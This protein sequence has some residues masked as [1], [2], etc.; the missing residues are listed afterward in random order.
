MKRKC[1][2]LGSS[3]VSILLISTL[4]GCT[5]PGSNPVSSAST[6]S[7]ESTENST[8]PLTMLPPETDGEAI[9]G[10]TGDNLDS[11]VRPGGGSGSFKQEM[12]IN[13]SGLDW[14]KSSYSK[15]NGWITR[16]FTFTNDNEGKCIMQADVTTKA[17]ELDITVMDSEGKELDTYKNIATS[18]FDINLGNGGDYQIRV[19]AQNHD[20]G[21]SIKQK[22]PN[23]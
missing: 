4:A 12:A 5:N 1:K 9:T 15:F 3:I 16:G 17:G 8:D 2:I 20:G 22:T 13:S 6:S 21:F 14:W 10:N 23:A 11:K 19:D 18:T 7:S